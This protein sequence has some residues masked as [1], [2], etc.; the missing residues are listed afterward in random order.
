MSARLLIVDDDLDIRTF[1]DIALRAYGYEVEARCAPH[2][3]PGEALPDVA[4]LDLLF[5]GRPPPEEFISGLIVG[6]VKVL[7]ISGLQRDD[8][9]VQRALTLGAHG[10]LQKPFTLDQLRA[11]VAALLK[12]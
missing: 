3:T 4:L 1:L 10:F 11:Q 5:G 9:R 6:G 12:A 8:P 2:L 7:L